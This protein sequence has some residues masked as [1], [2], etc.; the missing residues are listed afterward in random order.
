MLPED[1][2]SKPGDTVKEDLKS[3]HPKLRV[4]PGISL[5]EKYD[6]LQEL[7][8]IDITAD[9]VESVARRLS[10]S[11]GPRGTDASGLQHWLLQFGGASA[12]FRG[13]RK[14]EGK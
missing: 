9:T 3:K 6:T 4:V 13:V 10:G 11:A 14:M 12:E 5:M 7:V 8:E 2:D 1:I